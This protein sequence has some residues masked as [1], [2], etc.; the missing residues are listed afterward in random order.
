V[1]EDREEREGKWA[2]QRR[3]QRWSEEKQANQDLETQE[4]VAKD[5]GS[6]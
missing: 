1:A 6:R 5:S 3:D 2:E 4:A